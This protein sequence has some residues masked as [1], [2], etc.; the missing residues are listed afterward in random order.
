MIQK[1]LFLGYNIF[2]FRDYIKLIE[3][4]IVCINKL[5]I[6]CP[7]NYLYFNITN[8]TDACDFH[9]NLKNTR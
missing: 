5:N 3:D 7:K 9:S 8:Y 4:S 6:S 2:I 1:I